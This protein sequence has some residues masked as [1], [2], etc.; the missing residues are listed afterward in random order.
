MKTRI[1]AFFLWIYFFFGNHRK[2][3]YN[4]MEIYHYAY[5]KQR[6]ELYKLVKYTDGNDR[7]IKRAYNRVDDLVNYYYTIMVLL[8]QY[9]NTYSIAKQIISKTNM[10]ETFEKSYNSILSS[11]DIK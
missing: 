1:E 9:P 2:E 3:W 7:K 11:I 8:D 5:S 4:Q 10:I 6:E